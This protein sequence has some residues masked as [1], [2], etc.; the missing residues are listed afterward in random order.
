MAP[1]EPESHWGIWDP[2]RLAP[3]PAERGH[4]ASR[5]V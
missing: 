3:L 2:P 1:A 4:V 5:L